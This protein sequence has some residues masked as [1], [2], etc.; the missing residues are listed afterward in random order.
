M[1]IAVVG[2]C[3]KLGSSIVSELENNNIEAVK[4][5]KLLNNSLNLLNIPDAVIDASFKDAT[6][7]VAKYCNNVKIPLLICTT[8]HSLNQLQQI[9]QI[10]S[11]IAYTICP[12]A[13]LGMLYLFDCLKSLSALPIKNVNI[14]E[15][16]HINKKDSPSG[17]AIAIKN[18]LEKII[19]APISI[20]SIRKGTEVGTHCVCLTLPSEEITLIH[21]AFNRDIFAKGA[22]VLIT[23]LLTLSKGKHN[24]VDFLGDLKND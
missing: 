3:G 14:T 20:N 17:T 9:D 21:K 1:K 16:H 12:N 4:I 2:A 7:D 23:K 10:C 5:D 13:S 8:G 18:F 22:V 19:S 24:V 11:S 15:I 6:I